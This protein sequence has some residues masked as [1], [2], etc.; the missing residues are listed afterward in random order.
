[1]WPTKR[2]ERTETGSKYQIMETTKT[3]WRRERVEL[4]ERL[5]CS[6]EYG[7]DREAVLATRELFDFDASGRAIPKK[8]TFQNEDDAVRVVCAEIP[9]LTAQQWGNITQDVLNALHG[10]ATENGD[11]VETELKDVYV[12]DLDIM[13]VTLFY[14]SHPDDL[15][16][17]RADE[18]KSERLSR[19]ISL[20]HQL[21]SQFKP[22]WLA[23][24]KVVLASSGAILVLFQ[25]VQGDKDHKVRNAASNAEFG[26]DLLRQ[27]AQKTFPF[28]SKKSP[29]LIIHSTLARLISPDAFDEAALTRVREACQRISQ[30]L[31]NT[32]IPFVVNKL[33]YVDESHFIRPTGHTTT[34]PLGC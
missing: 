1:M 11:V 5:E 2:V 13:H 23:P 9:Q 18:H 30:Q 29:K 27:A 14:T 20:L 19:E 12:S 31:V 33:W 17:R 6:A 25:C 21:S 15:A 16:P 26:V 28:V 7:L 10:T 22:I 3:K 24:V 34:V 8:F 4:Y 32:A